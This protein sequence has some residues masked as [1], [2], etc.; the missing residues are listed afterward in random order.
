MGAIARRR[1]GRSRLRHQPLSRIEEN[2]PYGIIGGAM[3]TS[4]SFE[5]R[6]APSLYPT[7]T[8]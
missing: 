7:V 3:E 5:A 6:Y 4:A 2:S 8:A 1:P